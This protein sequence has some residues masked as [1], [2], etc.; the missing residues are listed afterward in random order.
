MN[1]K[2]ATRR[3]LTAYHEAGH[4]VA[5]YLLRKKFRYITVRPDGDYEGY[6]RH[7]RYTGY[8]QIKS[9]SASEKEIMV[10]LAGGAAIYLLTGRRDRLGALVDHHKA[11]DLAENIC[12]SRRECKAFVNWLYVRIEGILR[13]QANWHAVES[14]AE[15]LLTQETISY[16]KAAGLIKAAKRQFRQRG[17]KN[18]PGQ[19]LHFPVAGMC[20]TTAF[21]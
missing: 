21:P 5:A 11:M 6:M 12:A 20:G 14:L 17:W 9:R 7:R 4:A 3:T 1:Q 19:V 16:K 10:S 13:V 8:E 2:K 15:E 18:A